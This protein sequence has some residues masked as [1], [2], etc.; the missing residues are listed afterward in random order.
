L[1]AL[2]TFECETAVNAYSVTLSEAK[3]LSPIQMLRF[4]QH[5]M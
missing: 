3:G 2:R 4:A 5:D 1:F